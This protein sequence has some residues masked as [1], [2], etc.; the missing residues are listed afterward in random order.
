MLVS[1]YNDA[2]L[3]GPPLLTATNPIGYV[4]FSSITMTGS[5]YVNIDIT[6]PDVEVK[7]YKATYFSNE[8]PTVEF[9][10]LVK[11][12]L[13]LSGELINTAYISTTTPEISTLNNAASY[14]LSTQVTDLAITKTV[15]FASAGIG[16][17]LT[18]IITYE[19]K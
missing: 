1:V 16:E 10:S 5:L 19:N 18:Y 11:S 15:D 2:T 13:T 8:M 7:G 14:S 6:S 9:E 4:D 17:E 12:D 3:Q